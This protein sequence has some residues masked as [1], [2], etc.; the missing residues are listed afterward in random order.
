MKTLKKITFILIVTFASG[1]VQAQDKDVQAVLKDPVK[2]D[3]FIAALVKDHQLMQK[4]SEKMLQNDHALGMVVDGALQRAESD[5]TI[6]ENLAEMVGKYHAVS[7]VFVD[8]IIAVAED[9]PAMSHEICS[10]LMEHD[11]MKKD[12]CEHMK[13][14]EKKSGKGCC[15]MSGEMKKNK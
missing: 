6:A 10:D 12:M 13:Q 9:V 8:H 1:F 2:Q 7:L 3:Q 15:S 5:S 4:F 11:K 14:E